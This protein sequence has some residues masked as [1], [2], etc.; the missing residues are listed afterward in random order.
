MKNSQSTKMEMEKEKMKKTKPELVIPFAISI[1]E[2]MESLRL[3]LVIFNCG[4]KELAFVF[5]TGSDGSHINRSVVE[6][7]NL[8]TFT[9]EP[10]EG[11]LS[12]VS[13]G[14]GLREA[15][16]KMCVI[17]L[18]LEDYNFRVECSVEELDQVFNFIK[19]NDGI[20]LHGIL[21]TNFLRAN[22]WTID[23]ANNIVYPAFK[24][25]KKEK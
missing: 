23:F 18:S 17:R 22:N 5:D 10:G 2:T 24:V 15:T 7:L 16:N 1:A 25:N 20:Q 4:E 11:K 19:E 13:T 3:P 8:E 21:G 14:N 12:V 6:E 9:V